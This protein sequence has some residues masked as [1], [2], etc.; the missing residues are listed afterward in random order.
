MKDDG[1]RDDVFDEIYAAP[2]NL[3]IELFQRYSRWGS[4]Q[5]AVKQYHK[6][7]QTFRD[8]VETFLRE[9]DVYD[10]EF[11]TVPARNGTL[12]EVWI[13]YEEAAAV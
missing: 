12:Y 10:I 2:E 4:G 5:N 7:A 1:K 11:N 3:R 9:H 6:A 8:E 13:F